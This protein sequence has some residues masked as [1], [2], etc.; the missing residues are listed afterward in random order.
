M[1]SNAQALAVA[2]TRL[3]AI[4]LI[5]NAV[6]VA[7]QV[8]WVFGM[9]ARH[10]LGTL[11]VAALATTALLSSVWII[12]GRM[13]RAGLSAL[14]G[15]VAG[16]YML[17]I[18]ILLAALLGGRAAHLDVKV[19]GVSLIVAIVVGMFAETTVLTRTRIVTVETKGPDTGA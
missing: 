14:A 9:G 5:A 10:P 4:L 1:T 3:R 15:W 7:A 6:L 2:A 19:I 11:T 18:G 16:G 13:V 12:L 17:R 8:V